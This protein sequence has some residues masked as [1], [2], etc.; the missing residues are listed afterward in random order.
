MK[1]ILAALLIVLF[2]L[3]ALAALDP[4]TKDKYKLKIVLQCGAHN[5]LNES[6]RSDLRNNLAATLQDALGGMADVEVI[7]AKT[8]PFD[9]WPQ[10][11]KDVAGKG[12]SALDGAASPSSEKTHFLRIDFVNGQ[13][14]LQS[15][16]IDGATGVTSPLRR[17]HTSDRVVIV[18]LASRMIGEDF[19]IIGTVEGQGDNVRVRFKAGELDVPL[20]QWVH[21]GDIFALVQVSPPTGPADKTPRAKRLPD[22]LVQ[23][24]DDPKKGTCPARVVYRG[25]KN[26]LASPGR[27]AGFRCVKLDA[28]RGGTLRLRLVD[29]TTGQ[30]LTKALQVRVHP[31]GFQSG[32]SADDEVLIAEPNGLFV[33]KRKYD[34]IAFVRVVTGATVLAKIPVEILEDR[35]MTAALSLNPELESRGEL[36]N[37][38][39]ELERMF[40]EAAMV[41]ETLSKEIGALSTKQKNNAAALK[42]AKE[43]FQV[44]EGDLKLL[45]PELQNL[46]KET[47]GQKLNLDRCEKFD[48]DLQQQKT[49]VLKTIGRL[50]EL[51]RLEQDPTRL[52]QERHLKDL[53]NQGVLHEGNLDIDAA[54]ACFEQL[55]KES[56]DQPNVQKELDRLKAA[57]AVQNEDHRQARNFVYVELPRV[58]TLPDVETQLPAARQKLQVL[59]QANDQFTLQKLQNVTLEIQK[60]LEEA[61]QKFN[62]S[63]E[64]QDMEKNAKVKKIAEDFDKFRQEVFD[65]LKAKSGS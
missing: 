6:F 65:A 19:G 53:F 24:L 62:A 38:K 20:D 48:R 26:P 42:K 28:V 7:D 41:Q 49:A 17:D 34:G 23:L 1:Q 57:W 8:V 64:A 16:Q 56:K 5:W 12:L 63:E 33:S 2:P 44:L 60:R 32:E 9:Q 35:T 30:P 18:R 14:E 52:A 22:T 15:R 3:P 10:L 11:W 43:C 4:E 50:E 51:V 13:Y 39:N 36:D 21:R 29:F 27:A 25:I 37:R 47:G 40:A 46:K 31:E 55:L 58:K 61:I 45:E 54:I 59:K